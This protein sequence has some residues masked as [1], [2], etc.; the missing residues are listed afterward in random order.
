VGDYKGSYPDERLSRDS[1]KIIAWLNQGKEVYA[2]FNNTIGDAL[3]NTDR[4]KE[5]VDGSVSHI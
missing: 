3:N 1:D 5:L 4:L 2:Y